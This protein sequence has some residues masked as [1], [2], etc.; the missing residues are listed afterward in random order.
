[1]AFADTFGAAATFLNLADGT[2]TTTIESKSN[3]LAPAPVRTTVRGETTA[4]HRG[5]RTMVWR[6]GVASEPG[7]SIA[8]VMHSQLI[9]ELPQP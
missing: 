8:L 5:R 7:R 3:F 9:I 1:M 6:T 4:N 2:G